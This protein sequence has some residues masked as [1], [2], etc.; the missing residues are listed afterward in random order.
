MEVSADWCVAVEHWRL[1]SIRVI[2]VD[3]QTMSGAVHT[4]VEVRRM[5]SEMSGLVERPWL[6]L[7]CCAVCL[8]R[9]RNFR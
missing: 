4:G 8:P 6:Q 2:F 1:S 9:G 5:D 3:Y 7:M